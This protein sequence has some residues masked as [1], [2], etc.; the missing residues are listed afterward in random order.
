MRS[1][2]GWCALAVC[3]G[4][5][6]AH[7]QNSIDTTRLT[8]QQ[9][10]AE[11]LAKNPL[12]DVAREQT[13]QARARVVEAKA[14]PDPL[15]AASV[16]NNPNL[17]G[18]ASAIPVSVGL[19]V[20]DPWKLHR[21]GQVATTGLQSAEANLRLQQQTI[22]VQTSQAY[23][24][25]LAAVQHQR[26][27]RD[28]LT[29]A[30]GFLARTQ[31]Q[32]AAGAI[33]KLDVDQ[34]QVQAYAA[35]VALTASLHNIDIAQAALDHLLG[36]DR[37][38][39]VLPADTLVVPAALPDSARVI[40]IAL[41]NRPELAQALFNQQGA[42]LQTSLTKSFWLP[43]LAFSFQN[44]YAVGANAPLLLA[45][46]TMPIPFLWEHTR[47]DIAEAKHRELELAATTRDTRASILQD[48]RTTY[49]GAQSAIDQARSIRDQ[50]LP[51]AQEEYR[52]SLAAYQAGGASAIDV[53][54]A[55]QD[56][57][58]AQSQ[59]TDALAAA[60]SARADVERALGSPADRVGAI[61]P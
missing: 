2:W 32:Y 15:L 60:L 57:I 19:A 11:A 44:D 52:V 16:G 30:R 39:A 56:L 46:V 58:S 51:A 23:D 50:L 41:A 59:L 6:A 54:H 14:I 12:L 42:Q 27:L 25:L 34:A 53:I 37:A 24:Q 26:D 33:K 10:I 35:E 18:A 49:A 43:D 48:I 45:G 31:A 36:R 1:L 22:A 61:A 20:P 47:G 17:Q 8:R 55:Q 28:A 4:A 9:A 38:T 29:A 40:T 5:G 7:A 3:A 21:A 13:A